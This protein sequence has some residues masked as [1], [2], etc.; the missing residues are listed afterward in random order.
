M[1]GDMMEYADKKNKQDKRIAYKSGVTLMSLVITIIIVIILSSAAILSVIAIANNGK[2]V[3]FSTDLSNIEQ[4]VESYYLANKE[5][6]KITVPTEYTKSTLVVLSGPNGS[7]LES[8]IVSN[9][10]GGDTFFEIDLSKIKMTSSS[11]GLKQNGDNDIYVANS[12][13][14]RVY[15]VKGYKIGANTYFSLTEKLI[16]SSNVQ[17]TISS[18]DSMSVTVETSGIKIIKSKKGYTNNLDV[19]VSSVLEDGQTLRYSV[20]GTTSINITGSNCELK[21]NTTTM[22][23]IP[24]AVANFTNTTT[25]VKAFIVEK[26][27]SDGTTVIAKATMNIDNLD[28]QVPTIA[29]TPTPVLAA[30][31]DFNTI[32]LSNISDLGGAGIR[33]IRY[34]YYRKINSSSVEEDYLNPTTTID[35]KYLLSKGKKTAG[36][37]LKLDKHIASVKMMCIDNAG[38]VSDIKIYVVPTGNLIKE[39]QS[40]FMADVLTYR[41]R[42]L[43]DGGGVIDLW[44][45]N[46]NIAFLKSNNL[47]NN[48]VLYLSTIGGIKKNIV[49]DVPYVQKVYDLK[50][51]D[52]IQSTVAN[53]PKFTALG[54]QFEGASQF[55]PL[56]YATQYNIREAITISIWG[57]RTTGFN[58]TTDVHVLSRPP[59]WYFYDAYNSG[60][61]RGDVFIDGVRKYR[62]VPVPFDGNW[63]QI[64]FTYDSVTHEIA[65]YKNGVLSSTSTLTGLS[66]YLIDSSTYNF[67][68][69]GS[70]GLGRGWILNDALIFNKA[71]SGDEVLE[72][73]N[74]TKGRYI[75]Q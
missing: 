64:V 68:G 16:K 74:F 3:A 10:D 46:D 70:N 7:K 5:L 17:S 27:T 21:L 4:E 45:Y 42:V 54:M 25:P 47:Y 32:T 53:Q 12:R 11:R 57:K 28:I 30:F 52:G 73:Y 23:A 35:Q 59:S 29:D 63:Y 40:V 61:I 62:T 8:E 34:E 13:N 19:S 69:V 48:L 20:A 41:D 31:S 2:M 39:D 6:P 72:L 38:N 9:G 67:Q 18:T 44:K 37:I 33:E 22:S 51:N 26:L 49:S 66:N 60:D 36:N 15:Y 56:T 24:N 43:A 14:L 65:I 50:G 1:M 71:L 58:Q 55:I 75:P